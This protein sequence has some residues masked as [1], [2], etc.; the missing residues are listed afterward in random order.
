MQDMQP[1][2]QYIITKNDK[3][4]SFSIVEHEIDMS[5]LNRIIMPLYSHPSLQT[6]DISEYKVHHK[7]K[8][9]EILELAQES[10]RAYLIVKEL[11]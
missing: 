7:S 10:G 9:Y 8:V 1:T 3:L 5:D 6:I 4:T 11:T 2:Q